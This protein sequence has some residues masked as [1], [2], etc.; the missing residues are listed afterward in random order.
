MI[1]DLFAAAGVGLVAY[2]I[3]KL[4]IVIGDLTDK[5]KSK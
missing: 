3:L 4:L 1:A 2:C 5:E